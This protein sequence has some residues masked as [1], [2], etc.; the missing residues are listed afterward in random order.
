MS[1]RWAFKNELEKEVGPEEKKV[2]NPWY[3]WLCIVEIYSYKNVS[4]FTFG[5]G[6]WINSKML[7]IY[8]YILF[9]QISSKTRRFRCRLI[10]LWA[11]C[12]IDR[13]FCG[14]P[15]KQ[16]CCWFVRWIQIRRCTLM[17][18]MKGHSITFYTTIWCI[19]RYFKEKMW[20]M[21]LFYQQGTDG[22]YEKPTL[23]HHF[24]GRW[25]F[26][27]FGRQTCTVKKH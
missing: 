11:F 2:E 27:W 26:N 8:I 12:A 14:F 15:G 20:R 4:Q 23:K 24:K 17:F 1:D 18:N 21:G 6:T 5:P 9:W 10:Y 22:D 19:S 3:I 7:L 25:F 16:F 13:C